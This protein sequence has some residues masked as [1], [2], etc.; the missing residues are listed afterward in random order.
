MLPRF[1][2]DQEVQIFTVNSATLNGLNGKLLKPCR[3]QIIQSGPLINA[4]DSQLLFCSAC[5]C[6]VL[7]NGGR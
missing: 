4:N 2:D 7:S 6:A 5:D 3:M 1:A